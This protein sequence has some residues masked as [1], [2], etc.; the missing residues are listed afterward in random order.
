MKIELESMKDKVYLAIGVTHPVRQL[1][2][3]PS[4]RSGF[5]LLEGITHPPAKAVP[6]LLE[7]NIGNSPLEKG[8]VLLNI[9]DLSM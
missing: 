2:D 3:T 7:G 5:N 4:R 9:N 8:D 1:P 6:L